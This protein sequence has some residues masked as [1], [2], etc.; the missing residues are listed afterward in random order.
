MTRAKSIVVF[1]VIILAASSAFS[2][3]IIKFQLFDG[4]TVEGKLSLPTD[5]SNIKELVVYIHGTGPGTYD[6]HRK[7]GTLDFNYFDYFANEFTKRG[8]AFFS[9]SKRGVT[10]GDD[11]PLFDKVDREKFRKVVP[12]V[13]IK[14]IATF[15]STLRKDTRLKKAKVVLLGWS[16][17]TVLAAMAAEDKRNKVSAIFLCGYVN[18]NMADVIKWQNVGGSAMVSFRDA[19]DKNKDGLI[20][21]SEYEADD[22]IAI[23]F[24]KRLQGVQFEQLD[25]NKDNSITAADFEVL[26]KAKYDAILDAYNRGDEDWI[27]KNYFRISIPW[28]KEHF[29]L[30]ANKD[31]MLRLNMPIYIFHG[32]SDQ[33]CPV[34]GV[35]DIKSRFEKAGKTNLHVNVFPGH[36]H[37]LNFVD[38]VTKKEMPYGIA[39]IFQVA[40]GLNK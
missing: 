36:N 13:E 23:G 30:E 40:D 9:Y 24:R 14:D 8:L 38:W 35:Y 4:E 25:V 1:F 39:K 7:F 21:K 10:F 5:T 26:Q 27:W 20:S 15:I 12:S 34:E 18:D 37:D 29:A 3:E 19:F 32:E 17:G 2:S 28:L 6:D 33:N 11:P 22:K 16:E 31:R